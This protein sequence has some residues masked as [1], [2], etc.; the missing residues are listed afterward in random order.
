MSDD[1]RVEAS[2]ETVAEARWAALH[3]L[4][5]RHPDLDRDAVEF[6]VLSE[7]ERGVLGVGYEP[8]RVAALLTVVPAAREAAPPP[9]P[10]EAQVSMIG[11]E[12]PTPASDRLADML[13]AIVPA[14]AVDAEVRI[15]RR[16]APSCTRRSR[17]TIS[18]S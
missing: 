4:E 7:G 15:T 5:R 2:G 3:E 11:P 9:P 6:Q 1:V 17:A 12:P 16:E 8:V 14:I 13:G 18:A 10:V